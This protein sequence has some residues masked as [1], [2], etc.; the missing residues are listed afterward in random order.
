MPG[1]IRGKQVADT[2]L[3]AAKLVYTGQTYDFSGATALRA[4]TPSGSTD[5]ATK[6]YVDGLASGLDPKTG[7]RLATATTLPAYTPA[8]S[9]VGKTLTANANGALSVDGVAVAAGNRI[10]V[11][12][13]GGGTSVHNGIYAVT[14]AGSG[15]T[16]YI[17]TRATDFDGNPSGEVSEGSYTFVGEGVVNQGTGW[18]VSTADPITVDTTPL[19]F[20]L[21]NKNAHLTS[22]D[23]SLAPSVTSGNYSTTG[24]T[25]SAT[26][27]SGSQ[28]I[29]TVNGVRVVLG[30]G[31]RDDLGDFANN[32]EC[33][34][35][36]DGGTTAR[37]TAAIT[38][39]DTLYWNGT[40]A[41]YELAV[42]DQVSIDY[43]VF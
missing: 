36:A 12:D 18:F 23:K 4:P 28:P 26:P 25:L 24:I 20:S 7:V 15:G 9:G 30:N 34:F 6:S 22:A 21:F 27:L 8:G 40:H 13:E 11:K 29:V 42:T 2:T 41:G 17:L 32:V 16:P 38:A 19:T 39:G 3:T 31:N 10:L 35:S 43:E 33:Y 1:N 37:A 14:Q 5:V